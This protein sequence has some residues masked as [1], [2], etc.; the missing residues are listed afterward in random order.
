MC[1][2][3]AYATNCAQV[4]LNRPPVGNALFATPRFS[5][6]V[7]SCIVV[8]ILFPWNRGTNAEP[9][10]SNM[11]YV[12]AKQVELFELLVAK[13]PV[14]RDDSVGPRAPALMMLDLSSRLEQAGLARRRKREV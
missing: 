1:R 3:N 12:H 9:L 10:F 7:Y 2:I 6:K 14:P 8:Q 5:Y 4:S 11:S 13:R